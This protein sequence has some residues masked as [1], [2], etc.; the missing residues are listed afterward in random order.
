M[1]VDGLNSR[2]PG[3]EPLNTSTFT[4]RVALLSWR[5]V[6]G[7]QMGLGQWHSV[8]KRQCVLEFLGYREKEFDGVKISLL[9]LQLRFVEGIYHQMTC[10]GDGLIPDGLNAPTSSAWKELMENL[11]TFRS[12]S[13]DDVLVD[14]VDLFNGAMEKQNAYG[15]IDHIAKGG[16]DHSFITLISPACEDL[17]TRNHLSPA[18]NQTAD[19][20]GFEDAPKH[21]DQNES[22]D[23]FPEEY[24]ENDHYEFHPWWR[25]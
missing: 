11:R 13:V 19:K 7:E 9:M 6:E 17:W 24:S 22:Q 20:E 23:E 4:L 16:R 10:D 8:L 14:W 12:N 21:K 5:W 15:L 2:I 18:E 3:V 1:D 25:S